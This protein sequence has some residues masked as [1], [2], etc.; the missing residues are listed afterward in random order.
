[1]KPHVFQIKFGDGYESRISD[2][3][4]FMLAS[5]AV[6]FTSNETTINSILSFIEGQQ[7]LTP[8]SWTDP[9]G[10]INNFICREWSSS[11]IEFGVYQLNATFEQVLG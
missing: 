4:N 3:I 1:M 8:F 9:L 2:S 5:W 6:K 11:Q 10:N 7:A